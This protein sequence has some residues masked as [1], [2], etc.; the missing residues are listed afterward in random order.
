MEHD[1]IDRWYAVFCKPRQE[2]I[3]EENLALQGY[4]VHLPRI[5][6]RRRLHGRW[7]DTVEA[8]FPR[9]IFIR[10]NPAL[11]STAPVRSTRGVTG[12]V[13]FGSEPAIVPTA[14][15]DALIERADGVT[16]VHQDSRR[17]FR[18]GDPVK[19]VE[20]PF[21]GMEGIFNEQDGEKRVIVLLGLLGKANKVRISCDWIAQGA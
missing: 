18:P 4:W 21:T 9:Y 10:V 20:G 1:D 17:L 6:V 5:S 2:A 8:L 16:G 7:I 15:V 3:A 12:L 11:Q 19:V 13:R 14:V